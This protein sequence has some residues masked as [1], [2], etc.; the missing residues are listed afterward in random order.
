MLNQQI[1]E[2]KLREAGSSVAIHLTH[3]PPQVVCKAADR[4]AFFFCRSDH[5]NHTNHNTDKHV[6]HGHDCEE[7]EGKEDHPEKGVC[8]A[9]FV[10][11]RI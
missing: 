4:H 3:R 7:D 2:F 9:D 11:Q 6:R 5:A 10:G 1:L 8:S